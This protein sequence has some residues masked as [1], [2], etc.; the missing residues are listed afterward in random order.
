MPSPA[1]DVLGK[2]F[3]GIGLLAGVVANHAL[4]SR[5]TQAA[6][7]EAGLHYV[8]SLVPSQHPAL[9]AEALPGSPPCFYR[10][11]R[12]CRRTGR[13]RRSGAR[14]A[15]WRSCA[16]TG[17][18]RGLHQ[19]LSKRARA[20]AAQRA[21]VRQFRRP[22]LGGPLLLGSLQ[23]CPGRDRCDGRERSA[24]QPIETLDI[25]KARSTF[26]PEILLRTYRVFP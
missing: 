7:T 17:Q 10:L 20:L 13:A 11:G 16:R 23:L 9:L 12:R 3:F 18:V 21:N 1:P 15:R 22:S 24:A 6:V 26:P 5:A 25:F 14:S 19:Q 2:N 4:A 8:S